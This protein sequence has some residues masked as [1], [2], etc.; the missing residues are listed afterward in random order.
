MNV[1]LHVAQNT[2]RRRPAIDGLVT[3]L[4]GYAMSQRILKRIEEAFGWG[5]EAGRMRR[6][7]SREPTSRETENRGKLDGDD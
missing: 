5:K 4:A 2:S 3:R 1:K 6:T 7:R